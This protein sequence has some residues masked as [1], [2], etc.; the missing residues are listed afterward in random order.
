MLSDT[1]SD[2]TFVTVVVT[3][4][5]SQTLD[6]RKK[7]LRAHPPRDFLSTKDR[8]KNSTG[9]LWLSRLLLLIILLRKAERQVIVEHLDAGGNTLQGSLPLV[10]VDG[11]F[12]CLQGSLNGR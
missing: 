9:N 3:L 8:T 4:V 10:R 5:D 2:T 6:K 7:A 1:T 11:F 12:I